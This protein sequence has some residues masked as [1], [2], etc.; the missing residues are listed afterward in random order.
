MRKSNLLE[1][2]EKFIEHKFELEIIDLFYLIGFQNNHKFNF[3]KK[4]LNY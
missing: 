3:K 4:I 2:L 1:D